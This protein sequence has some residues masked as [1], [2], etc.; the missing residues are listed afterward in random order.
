VWW[1]YQ[2]I[3]IQPGVMPTDGYNSITV[4]DPSTPTYSVGPNSPTNFA[5][6]TG[7]IP[8][9]VIPSVSPWSGALAALA[10]GAAAWLGRRTLSRRET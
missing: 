3:V 10:L 1:F 9:S 2:T 5:G 7:S 8:A 6:Q 4:V